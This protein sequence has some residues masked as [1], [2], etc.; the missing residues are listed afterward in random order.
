MQGLWGLPDQLGVTFHV[1]LLCLSR[2]TGPGESRRVCEAR[3]RAGV[4]GWGGGRVQGTVGPLD[5]VQGL[6]PH[7]SGGSASPAKTHLPHRE[8][9]PL[10]LEHNSE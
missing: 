9:I 5:A 7:G 10:A 4:G 6:L 3:P 2:K 8:P 1:L